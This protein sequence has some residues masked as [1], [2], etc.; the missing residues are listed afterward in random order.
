[1][2]RSRVSPP[3][4]QLSRSRNSATASSR[5]RNRCSNRLNS[6]SRVAMIPIWKRTFQMQSA[7]GSGGYSAWWDRR[8]ERPLDHA[9]ARRCQGPEEVDPAAADRVHF[10][11]GGLEVDHHQRIRG[12]DDIEGAG[13]GGRI[14]LS[15]GSSMIATVTPSRTAYSRS[16]R[17]IGAEGSTAVTRHPRCA[18][19]TARVPGPAPI[20]RTVAPPGIAIDV[21]WRSVYTSYRAAAS[22]WYRSAF[23]AFP[24]NSIPDRYP[25]V[26]SWTLLHRHPGVVPIVPA[27][28]APHLPVITRQTLLPGVPLQPRTARAACPQAYL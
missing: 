21:S 9:P 6:A 8:P 18:R 26:T 24:K 10:C 27:R 7:S 25:G 5:S 3:S 17:R 19:G 11:E 2:E 1:M 22:R 13:E 14:D 15:H 23:S 16:A 28:G 4:G 20:S 12:D